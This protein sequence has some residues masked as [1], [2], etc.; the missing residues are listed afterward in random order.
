MGRAGRWRRPSED[1]QGGIPPYAPD[2]ALPIYLYWGLEKQR[3]CWKVG[4]TMSCRE[5]EC[6]V[7]LDIYGHFRE[8]SGIC[9]PTC[10]SAAKGDIAITHERGCRARS[11]GGGWRC[12]GKCGDWTLLDNSLHIVTL[13]R[14]GRHLCAI[15]ARR[16]YYRHTGNRMLHCVLREGWCAGG[17]DWTQLHTGAQYATYSY[18]LGDFGAPEAVAGGTGVLR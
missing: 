2:G 12:A 18:T 7:S 13:W 10:P 11:Q 5:G 9:Q 6:R 1:R 3:L 16:G 15:A 17:D 14:I 8:K 4:E